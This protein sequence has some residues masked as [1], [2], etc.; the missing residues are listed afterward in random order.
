MIRTAIDRSTHQRLTQCSRVGVARNCRANALRNIVLS[1][2]V[3][4]GLTTAAAADR[5]WVLW[6]YIT[7]SRAFSTGEWR[8]VE[9]YDHLADCRNAATANAQGKREAYL[10]IRGDA[11]FNVVK[12]GTPWDPKRPS[13]TP[14]QARAEA[15]RDTDS[16]ITVR[17]GYFEMRIKSGRPLVF[18]HVCLPNTVDPRGPDGATGD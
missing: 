3:L 7:D 4:T 5:A 12:G 11:A 16:L 17:D 1:V 2:L 15:R 14:D 6:V 10:G 18:D 13:L 9:E 8:V